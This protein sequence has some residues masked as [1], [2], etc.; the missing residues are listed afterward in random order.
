MMI[1]IATFLPFLLGLVLLYRKLIKLR[2]FRLNGTSDSGREI[3][4][5]VNS[6]DCIDSDCI[7]K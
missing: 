5:L 2:D 6:S 4:E 1:L 3:Y 7:D